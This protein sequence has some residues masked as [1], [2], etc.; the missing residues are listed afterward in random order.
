MYCT[1]CGREM[2]ER[3]NFCPS[4]GKP[5]HAAEAANPDPKA[6]RRLY[7]SMRNKKIA[8]VCAGFAQY[9]DVDVTM[10]RIVWLVVALLY[11][12]GVI[13]YLIA[14]IAMPKEESLQQPA[15]TAS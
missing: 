8:G 2:A 4:C 6:R 1:G 9:L 10:V 5:V 11:G 12:T 15:T 13:A 14:W 7:R 3:D